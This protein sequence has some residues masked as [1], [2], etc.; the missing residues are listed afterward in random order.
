MRWRSRSRPCC[1]I[2]G[3]TAVCLSAAITITSSCTWRRPVGHEAHA[4]WLRAWTKAVELW[5]DHRRAVIIASAARADRKAVS[6][7][8]AMRTTSS[9][10]RGVPADAV[11][12]EDRSTTTM[13]EPAQ[14]QSHHGRGRAQART[15]AVVTS[16]YH[17]SVR[18]STR[19]R[20]A[21][22]RRR[23]QQDRA[24]SWPTAFIREYVAV[25]NPT[26]GRSWIHLRVL[27]PFRRHRAVPAVTRFAPA[28]A[29]H[30]L[31]R[32]AR[33]CV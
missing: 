18:P 26:A 20:S 23:G 32:R 10:E 13:E 2:R 15:A 14:L 16:D 24:T 3:C 4:C 1:C 19:T 21:G 12:E 27:A 29:S 8:E 30:G 11:I 9:R 31:T 6:E 5:S 25:S 7:A 28:P 22:R 33:T 17:C